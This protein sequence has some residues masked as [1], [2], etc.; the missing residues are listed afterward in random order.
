MHGWNPL[1]PVGDLQGCCRP[2]HFQGS[3]WMSLRYPSGHQPSDLHALYLPSSL[4]IMPHHMYRPVPQGSRPH[5]YFLRYGKDA[6]RAVGLVRGDAVDAKGRPIRDVKVGGGG[7]C[8]FKPLI[9]VHW[10]ATCRV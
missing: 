9:G 4:D 5:V 8:L 3:H 1:V 7:W 2:K 10:R 6:V